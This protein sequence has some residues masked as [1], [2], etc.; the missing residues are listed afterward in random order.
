MSVTVK[1]FER[2]ATL[3]LLNYL[4]GYIYDKFMSM[5]FYE[6]SVFETCIV[7]DNEN[8][9]EKKSVDSRL[10]M[11]ELKSK[12]KKKPGTFQQKLL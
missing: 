10:N 5:S 8:H 11:H 6:F 4:V 2:A 1:L 3:F 9:A 12:T 7:A